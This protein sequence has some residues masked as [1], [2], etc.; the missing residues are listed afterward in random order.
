MQ[1][2]VTQISSPALSAPTSTAPAD[3]NASPA[4]P[5]G[6]I[7]AR[8]IAD[9]VTLD[10]L[11][12]SEIA[13]P[14][15]SADEDMHTATTT[16]K[17]KSDETQTPPVPDGVSAL[18]GDM[19]AA[20]LP[21]NIITQ[22][23]NVHSQSSQSEAIPNIHS[24]SSRSEA[25]PNIHSQS[26][27]SEA[28]PNIHSQSSRSEALLNVHSQQFGRSEAI[29]GEQ[30][31]PV[32][33][34]HV[35]K[36][37]ETPNAALD[38]INP[39]HEIKNQALLADT[40]LAPSTH[41]QLDAPQPN[42]PDLTALPVQ[43]SHTPPL[44]SP[45]QQTVNTPLAHSAWADDFSQKIVWVA[46]QHEQSAELHLNPPQLGPLDVSIKVNGD[47]ATAIFTSPH[48]VVRD[49]I[50]QALPKLREMLAD[51]GIMLG[52]ASVS[53]QSPREQQAGQSGHPQKREGWQTKIDQAILVG[54]PAIG[55]GRRQQGLVDT[56]A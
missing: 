8:Q 54:S 25:I 40:Q 41:A 10:E 51:N 4:E 11:N 39:G 9:N 42:T 28:I 50:E 24:Q 1:N 43:M 44:S 52:N 21:A 37:H 5:F 6:N 45:I 20:L 53:D 32:D 15:I 55:S 29:M 22:I 38:M 12:S 30:T 36:G 49:A 13:L 2:I 27:R 26:S 48:A 18:P 47:Q 17:E 31:Q 56:F 3:S 19:L 46:T 33:I 14:I 23:S 34:G 16:G 35:L 7:L